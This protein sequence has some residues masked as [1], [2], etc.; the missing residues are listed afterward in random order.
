MFYCA[1]TGD[2][3]VSKIGHIGNVIQNVELVPFEGDA[4]KEADLVR[5]PVL[6]EEDVDVAAER[7]LVKA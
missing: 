5:Q 4:L 1:N 3:E 6:E 2:Q 7:E